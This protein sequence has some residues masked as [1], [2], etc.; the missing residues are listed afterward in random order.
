MI[1]SHVTSL[2]GLRAAHLPPVDKHRDDR[3]RVLFLSQLSAGFRTYASQL[4]AYAT[5][6]DDVDALFVDLPIPMWISALGKSIPLLRRRGWDFHSYRHLR[7]WRRELHRAIRRGPL[8]F[9]RFD[10]VHIMTQGA[11][12][13]LPELRSE[14]SARVAVNIDG[15]ARQ[16]VDE[17]GFS[18]LARRPFI[19]EEERIFRAADLIVCRNRF[20]PTSL[21][22]DYGVPDERILIARNAMHLSAR[23]RWDA[24][25]DP[26]GPVRLVFVGS[27]IGRKGLPELIRAHQ[28]HLADRAELHIV[29]RDRL[30]VG[31]LQRV[32][33][34]HEVPRAAL[35]NEVLPSMDVFVMW[36][37][38]DQQPWA[39][40]EAASVGLPVVSTDLAAIPDLVR[41][42]E[43]GLLAP[44][45]DWPQL[46]AHTMRL[47]NDA[48]LRERFGRAAREH[49]RRSFN[50]D[51]EFNHLFDALVEPAEKK[52][53][54]GSRLSPLP[55]G[56]D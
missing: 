16:D 40:L 34:H 20:A 2:T 36:T 11:A 54:D 18:P 19:R 24:P 42:G 5:E 48:A 49:V 23:S 55:A 39:I 45:R 35:L 53:H 14:T 33:L 32:T 43:T 38:R 10:A 37:K 4:R 13:I 3:A 22:A 21:A 9:N 6:R 56:L 28:Q 8:D 52:I 27:D 31:G 47:V 7:M 46:L 50:P 12:L 44:P 29:T 1:R 17:F 25:R 15:T 30:S 26:G 51:E 41:H